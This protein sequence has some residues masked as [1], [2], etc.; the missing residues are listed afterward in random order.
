MGAD[1]PLGR[2][3]SAHLANIR[4][5]VS[6]LASEAGLRDPDDFALSWNVLMTGAIVQ[7]A[8][9]DRK[10]AARAKLIAAPLIERYRA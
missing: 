10:A 2:A 7:A 5:M 9:G 8:E 6:Q 4:G 3:S 1:H